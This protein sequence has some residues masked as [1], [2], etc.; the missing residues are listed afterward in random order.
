[1]T[2]LK[3]KEKKINEK[4]SGQMKLKNNFKN[5]KMIYFLQH[6]SRFRIMRAS[7]TTYSSFRF[8]DRSGTL[9]I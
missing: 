4:F 3:E 7:V 1:M 6:F 2:T 5:V 8:G 9:K